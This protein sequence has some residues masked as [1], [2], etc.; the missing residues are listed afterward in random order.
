MTDG[1]LMP[2]DPDGMG[3]FTMDDGTFVLMRN[4]EIDFDE[5]DKAPS[6]QKRSS[7]EPT[8]NSQA[9][10]GV[11][12]LVL[13]KNLNLISSNMVLTGT[14]Q[15]CGGGVSPWGWFTCEETRDDGHGFVFL[16]DPKANRVQA[17]RRLPFLGRF[18][19]EAAVHHEGNI[20]LT[21]DRD[22]SCLYRMVPNSESTPFEGKLQA[23]GLKNNNTSKNADE[24]FQG[25]VAEVEWLDL[26]TS[27]LNDTEI[28]QTAL[29]LGAVQFSRGEGMWAF[30]D[31]IYF[32]ATEGGQKKLGQIFEL[33]V[34]NPN[35][36]NLKLLAV[37]AS[38]QMSEK[39]DSITVGPSGLIFVAEDGK[40]NLNYIHLI[41]KNGSFIRFAETAKDEA[42]GICLT[43]DGKTMFLNLQSTG[44]TL[45][46]SGDFEEFARHNSF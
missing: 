17:P 39:V 46:V 1:H 41:S 27:V 44:V 42:C 15:N 20:Y 6:L 36:H 2:G 19:H 31:K 16:C 5:S 43:P 37:S 23:L 28:S 4:H 7:N 26:P 34:S 25:N 13:D 30:E 35:S 33:D 24:W 22:E 14:I 21:E 45:A 11:S 3:C 40:E 9:C 8:F 10:G 12:R 38:E 18:K 29:K 32:T